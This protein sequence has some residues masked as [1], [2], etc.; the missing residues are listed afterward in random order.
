MNRRTFLKRLVVMLVMAGGGMS[1]LVYGANSPSQSSIL[2]ARQD[3]RSSE[4][5]FDFVM[6]H[7]DL[8]F[9]E[10]VN[11]LALRGTMA[12]PILREYPFP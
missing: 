10:A 8:T 6:S 4:E 7:N 5:I 1:P 12:D 2:Q 3:F 11:L 9:E